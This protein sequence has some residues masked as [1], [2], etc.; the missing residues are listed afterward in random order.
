MN[1]YMPFKQI[2]EDRWWIAH[3]CPKHHIDEIPTTVQDAIIHISRIAVNAS[4]ERYLSYYLLTGTDM[5]GMNAHRKSKSKSWLRFKKKH[6]EELTHLR[7]A[8]TL[9]KFR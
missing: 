1:T 8:I 9:L 5:P 7:R 2:Y 3:L 4:I 6:K